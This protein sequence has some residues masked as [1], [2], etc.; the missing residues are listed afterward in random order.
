MKKSFLLLHIS[1]FLASITGIFGKLI[2]LN[3][4]LITFYR[5]LLAGILFIIIS[6]FIDKT[7]KKYTILEYLKIANVG[8]LL[9]LHWIFFYGSI[10]YSNIS[11]GVV[12]FCLA[13]F[14]TAI[15]EPFI[16]N[17]KHSIIEILLSCLTL[18][19][20]ALI[21]SFDTKYRLGIILGVISSLF[22]AIYTI[23]NEGLVKKYETKELTKVEMLGGT[24]GIVIL[25]PILLKFYSIG[26][27]IPTIK[28][29]IYLLILSGICT[30]LLYWILNIAMKKISAFTVNLSFNLEPIYSII[31][32]VLFF[33]EYKELNLSFF[34]GLSLIIL[35]L[36]LQMFR[37]FKIK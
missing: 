11:V 6:V 7:E 24:I 30:V 34:I 21:F 5:M 15:I 27:F 22:V 36:I 4:V 8:F 25:L 29:L 31:I 1:V 28:D 13:G 3:E 19:G 17:K 2:S 32:A 33:N 26:T 12:C 18:V 10:K 35:S 23:L 16:N 14:F 9:G 37:I 20:I